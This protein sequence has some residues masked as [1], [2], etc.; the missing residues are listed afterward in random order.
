MTK[1]Q[2]VEALVKLAVMISVETPKRRNPYSPSAYVSWDHII[3]MREHVAALGYDLGE[4][5]A[6]MDAILAERRGKR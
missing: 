6:R 2:H 5:R 1:Q 4:I 3:T